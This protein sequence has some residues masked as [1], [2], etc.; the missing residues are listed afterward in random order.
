[1]REYTKTYPPACVGELLALSKPGGL[2][3]RLGLI[4]R[5]TVQAFSLLD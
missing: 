4:A 3:D 2:L 5:W 1:M